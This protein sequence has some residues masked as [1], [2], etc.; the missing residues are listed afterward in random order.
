MNPAAKR[1]LFPTAG[2]GCDWGMWLIF[3]KEGP[4]QKPTRSIG[5]G[6]FLS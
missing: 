1:M 6:I 5:K 4:P 3:S 2:N